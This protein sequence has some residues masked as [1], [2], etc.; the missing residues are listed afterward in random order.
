ME[1]IISILTQG[2]TGVFKIAA[3]GFDFITGNDLCMFM[4]CISFAGV[5]L[6]FVKRAFR[7]A[8]K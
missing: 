6:G 5:A 7:T 2:V 8:R 1:G 3:Q 4:V